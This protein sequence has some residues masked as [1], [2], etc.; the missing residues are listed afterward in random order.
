MPKYIDNDVY[1]TEAVTRYN[2]VAGTHKM[3][4]TNPVR[5]WES[6]DPDEAELEVCLLNARNRM[7]GSNERWEVGA[8]PE[9]AVV[10][11][12]SI[13]VS[14]TVLE[15]ERLAQLLSNQTELK[16]RDANILRKIKRAMYLPV[17]M[18][19]VSFYRLDNMEVTGKGRNY[20][21]TADLE[22]LTTS[23]Y[24][25]MNEAWEAYL[26]VIRENASDDCRIPPAKYVFERLGAGDCI[27]HSYFNIASESFE[28]IAVEAVPGILDTLGVNQSK[29][30]TV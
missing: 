8:Q 26:D 2:I 28:C 11:Y 15:A 9:D 18:F 27:Y 22:L 20:K 6:F 13:P 17:Q 19:Y 7:N 3:L 23:G 21:H 10:N 29:D 14:L 25:T 12:C 1:K 16:G 4:L 24:Q 5:E 30:V